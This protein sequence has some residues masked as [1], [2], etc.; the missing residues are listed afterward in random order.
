MSNAI[1]KS[2]SALIIVESPNKVK[3]ITAI[4][5]QA[6]FNKAAV[7]ASVGHIMKLADGGTAFNSGIYPDKNFKMNL[8]IDATKQKVVRELK[9]KAEKAD[10]IFI[11]TD[12]DREGE[13]IAWSIIHFCKFPEHKCHRVITKEI[14]SNAVI[15]ALNNPIAFNYNLIHA[16]MARLMSDKLIGYGLSPIGKKYIGARSIGRCQS[17]GLKLIADR[18]NDILNFIPDTFY[19]PILNFVK[20][21]EAFSARYLGYKTEKISTFDNEHDANVVVLS[22]ANTPFIVSEATTLKHIQKPPSAFCTATFQQE[23]AKTLG[24]KVKDAMSC[25]QKLF[26]GININGQHTGLITYMRTDSTEI[27][28]DFLPTLES[29][30]SKSFGTTMYQGPRTTKKHSTDQLGHEALRIVDPE[31]T[32]EV[33]ENYITNKLLV[34][35]YKLIWQRTIASVMPNAIQ[36]ERQYII[37]NNDHKFILSNNYITHPGYHIAFNKQAANISDILEINETLDNTSLVIDKQLTKPK[38]RYTEASL[39]H[40]LEERG[41]GRPSTY[42]TIIETLLNPTR[43]Y[44]TCEKKE[45]IP[46]ER[47]LQLASYCDRAFSSIINLKYTKELEQLLDKIANGELALLDYMTMFYDHLTSVINTTNETGIVNELPE[48]LCP[49][50]GKPM[51][52][53]RSRFGKLFYGC[54]SYPACRG[55]SGID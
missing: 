12:G 11:M 15:A 48:K 36:S 23:A 49:L 2:E 31:I 45:I 17:V 38:P 33:L 6:G 20:N 13:L 44:A 16:G 46:T 41:I 37:T 54:S 39:V 40:E 52:V 25:A 47:G 24:L 34:K 28:K 18:E 9:E 22:C 3:T 50:C 4:L 29:F 51:V 1:K 19:K 43:G 10:R 14:T 53:R 21:G 32:P 8:E 42:A 7:A 27:S 5:K 26:E 30:I 35:V 55:I